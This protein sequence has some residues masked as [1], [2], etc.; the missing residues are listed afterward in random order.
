MPSAWWPAVELV[1][2]ASRKM[3]NLSEKV[4]PRAGRAIALVVLYAMVA[5]LALG[6]NPFRGETTGPFD[7]LA[8]Y[9]G[10]ELQEGGAG[11]RNAQRSDILDALLPMWLNAKEQMRAGIVPLW[12]PLRAGGFPALLDPTN[13]MLTPAFLVFALIPDNALGFYFATL[14][15]LVMAGMGMHV[16][17]RRYAPAYAAMFAGISYMMCGFITGWLFWPH[18]MTAIWI[19][20]LLLAV[21]AYVARGEPWKLLS[22]AVPAGLMFLGGFPI[23]AAMGFGAALAW[24]GFK[25]LES[26]DSRMIGRSLLGVAAAL[27]LG[28]ALVA[29]PFLTFKDT[30]DATDMSSRSFGTPLDLERGAKLLTWWWAKDD[31]KVE[32]SYYVGMLALAF[33]ALGLLA[34]LFRKRSL[35]T[36]SRVGLLLALVGVVLAFGILPRQIGA[37]IPVLSSNGWVRFSLLLDIGLILMAAGGL[38]W[39]GSVIRPRWM[40]LPLA[41]VLLLAQAADLGDQFRNFNGAADGRLFYHQNSAIEAL[42]K[43]IRPFQYVGQDSQEYLLGGTLGA[44][45][46]G[47]WHAHSLR[48]VAMRDFLNAMEPASMQTATSSRLDINRFRWKSKLL[49]AAGLCYGLASSD[50]LPLSLLRRIE[51]K[52]R[53]PLPPISSGYRQS[54][55]LDRKTELTAIGIRLATY[56]QRWLDGELRLSVF[57][58][59]GNDLSVRVHEDVSAIRDNELRTFAFD[60]ALELA[61]G[62][63]SLALEYHPGPKKMKLTAWYFPDAKGSVIANGRTLPGSME[64]ALFGAENVDMESAFSQGRH[65]YV[66]NEGCAEGAYFTPTLEQDVPEIVNGRVRLEAYRPHRFTLSVSAGLAGHVVVPMQFRNGWQVAIDGREAPVDTVLGVMPSVRVGADATTLEFVYTPPGLIRGMVV[67]LLSAVLLMVLWWMPAR[68][69]AGR[70]GMFGIGVFAIAA[71]LAGLLL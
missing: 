30:L 31:P 38:A 53:V 33:A 52:R 45:G 23:V 54:F 34:V 19:P 9:P 25:S 4:R 28:V 18:V 58:A 5:A 16:L 69:M 39:M 11:V 55:G 13:A 46:L 67:S 63:Y 49:D 2:D 24:A 48:S 50:W 71:V 27:M 1:G 68:R 70:E 21:D 14:L 3:I 59:D 42:R 37:H 60:R 10:W 7:L 32:T 64:Y 26:A 51:G 20:W 57:D 65:Q 8:S 29:I 66:V 12:N 41:S 61:P 22:M 47:E 35:D 36:M 17:V 40:V 15:N 62:S 56:R 44:V 43:Q 6:A